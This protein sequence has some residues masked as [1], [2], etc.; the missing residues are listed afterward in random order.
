MRARVVTIVAAVGLVVGLAGSLAACSTPDDSSAP[1]T[2]APAATVTTIPSTIVTT[3]VTTSTTIT[4]TTPAPPTASPTTAGLTPPP[5]SPC[6]LGSNPDCIDPLRTGQGVYLIGGADCMATSPD[7]ALCM[8][9]DG[10]G[11]AGYPDYG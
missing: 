8:D 2:T 9:L 3:V 4:P 1:P 6:A 10:D 7:P 5:G 11:L